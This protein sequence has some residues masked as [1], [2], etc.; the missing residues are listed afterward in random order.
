MIR[1]ARRALLLAASL[2]TSAAHAA[3]DFILHN[4]KIVTVDANFS[5]AEAVAVEQGRILAV[6]RNDNV[7]KTAGPETI[8]VDM[9]GQTILPGMADTH[10][11]LVGK[12]RN[13]AIAIDLSPVTSIADIQK[14]VR[15]RAATIPKGEWIVG[16]RGWWEY[17]LSDGR[18]PTRADLDK[19]APDHPVSIPGPHYSIANSLALKLAG[20]DKNTPNPP[21][22]EIWKD[23]KTGEP[24]GLLMDRAYRPMSALHPRAT[25]ADVRKGVEMLLARAASNGV[26]SIGET[27]GSLEEEALLRQIHDDGKLTLRVDY[28]FN[29]DL[30][31]PMDDIERQLIALGPPGRAW[32]NGMFRADTLSET[33]LDGAELTAHLRQ[34]YPGKPGYRG[35]ELVPAEQFRAFARLANLHGWRLR[36]HAVGDAAIDKALDAFELA[37]RDKSII[38]R[39]WMID[40]AFLLQPDHYPRVKALG[41]IINSQYMHNAQLGKLILEAWERPLADRSEAYRDWVENDI[42]FANGSDGPVSYHS[43]PILMIWGSVTRET[44]WGGSLGPDQGLS[45]EAAIRSVTINSAHTTFEEQVKGS[46]EPGKYADMVVLSDDILAVPASRIKDIKV[47]ATLLGGK[48][49]WGQL[50][51]LPAPVWATALSAR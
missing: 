29:V 10:Q 23:P 12:G 26:T 45:R 11:S 25:P 4:A 14:L 33:G 30:S 32:G 31:K 46:I 35:L 49:V 20:I 18:L 17:Q 37:N 6:G 34:D 24:N 2:G 41:M 50:P 42:L 27:S 38:G 47:K 44:L 48:P 1:A 43:E 7:L 16:T 15:A 9:A 39:R 3:P 8:K 28:G 5:I 22:G 19:A 40:H 36:P 21:G 13:F 51:G